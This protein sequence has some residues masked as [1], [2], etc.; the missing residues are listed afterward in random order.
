MGMPSSLPYPGERGRSM[1]RAGEETSTSERS[2]STARAAS[3]ARQLK[4][5][6]REQKIIKAREKEVNAQEALA[7]KKLESENGKSKKVKVGPRASLSCNVCRRRKVRCTGE[8]PVCGF[9]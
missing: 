6:A 8:W 2:P 9:W 3:R 4:E 1:N 7:K 5:Q